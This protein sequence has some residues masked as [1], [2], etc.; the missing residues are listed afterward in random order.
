MRGKVSRTL[1]LRGTFERRHEADRFLREPGDAALVSRVRDRALVLACPDGCGDTLTVNLDRKA[2]PA[3]RLYRRDRGISVFPSVWRE[4]GCRSHFVIWHGRI[5]WC[6]RFEDGN[7]EPDRLF[8]LGAEVRRILDDM[9]RPAA[10]I[11]DRLGQVP[12]D[13]SRTCQ[14][15][16]KD[17]HS[18]EGQD[19][20]R[21]HYRRS[22]SPS[23]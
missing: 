13:V 12:W 20:L 18:E 4:S 8:G 15:L 9:F 22:G 6:D 17:G 1:A 10:E 21:G 19:E 7:R 2:G 16:E 11:A 14:E 3:W 23:A 5:L